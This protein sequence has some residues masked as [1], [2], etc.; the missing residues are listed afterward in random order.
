[1]VNFVYIYFF[2]RR[3]KVKH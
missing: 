3:H 2:L 1:M